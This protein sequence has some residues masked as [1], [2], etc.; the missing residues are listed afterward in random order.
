MNDPNA[1]VAQ[2]DQ[3]Q[4]ILK[5]VQE[6]KNIE[7]DIE[8]SPIELEKQADQNRLKLLQSLYSAPAAGKQFNYTLCENFDGSLLQQTPAP[9]QQTTY[10]A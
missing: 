6:A 8:Q 1:R 10:T 7:K 5:A 3:A 4:H 2:G 9:L